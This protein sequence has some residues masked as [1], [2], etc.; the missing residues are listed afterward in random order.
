VKYY[1]EALEESV[2]LEFRNNESLATIKG[3][4]KDFLGMSGLDSM[5][6]EG[7]LVLKA[8]R[9]ESLCRAWGLA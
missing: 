7:E 3:V 6:S 1:C 5:L 4:E 8:R 9:I 2:Y